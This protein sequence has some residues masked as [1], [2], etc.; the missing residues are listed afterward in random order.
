MNSAVGTVF[1]SSSLFHAGGPPIGSAVT[2]GW[3]LGASY[4][5]TQTTWRTYGK[6]SSF[7]RPGPANVFVMMDENPYSI[8]DG[9]IAI[10]ATV[11]AGATYLV[12]CPAGN[13]GQSAGIA[14]AD[15]HAIVHKWKDSRTYTPVNFIAP[16]MGGV[17]SRL[18][19]PTDDQDCFYLS[20]I[21]SAPQ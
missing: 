9:S 2:G 10:A 12:D 15:G 18:Q 4:V 14:F 5:N 11:A 21:T 16:G 6:S 3:L 1:N 7:S 17:G 19:T 8:N 13:H 20:S